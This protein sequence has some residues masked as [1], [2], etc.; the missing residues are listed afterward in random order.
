MNLKTLI[1]KLYT[2]FIFFLIG[3]IMRILLIYYGRDNTIHNIFNLYLAPLTDVSSDVTHNKIIV[4]ISSFEL[5]TY[6]WFSLH[7][8]DTFNGK[9]TT[10]ATLIHFDFKFSI[11]L[12]AD[13]CKIPRA[14]R[15][16]FRVSENIIL[17]YL[18]WFIR[19][20]E[21]YASRKLIRKNQ[22]YFKIQ[23]VQNTV[24]RLFS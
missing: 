1:W 8:V 18:L 12:C 16:H 20:A 7:S 24:G 9:L 2:Y 10:E 4:D 14:E 17:N 6:F 19:I 11:I 21:L 13:D 5:E 22:F 23:S 3:T 15:S